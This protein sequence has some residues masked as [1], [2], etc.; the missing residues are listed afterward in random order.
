M[1]DSVSSVPN[2][3]L[4]VSLL[5][6]W[7]GVEQVILCGTFTQLPKN[8]LDGNARAADDGLAHHDFGVHLDTIR[9]GHQMTPSLAGG[10]LTIVELAKGRVGSAI[11]PSQFPLEPL[12]RLARS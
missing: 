5:E 3:S 4:D 11:N 10:K 8:Q 2:G 9:N 12:V 6:T 7:V 1:G